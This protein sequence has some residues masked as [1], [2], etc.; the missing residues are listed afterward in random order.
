MFN[1]NKAFSRNIGWVSKEEQRLLKYKKIAVAGCGGVGSEHV[2]TLARLGIGRFSISDFDEYEVHNFNRQAGA[3]MSTIDRPKNTVMREV[4][5]DINPQ[6]H[7]D[8]FP[9]GVNEDNVDEFLRDVDVYVDGLDFFA[10]NARFM[11][12]KRCEE[13]GIPVIT[14]APM[15]MGASLVCF[16]PGSMPFEEYFDFASCKTEE[17]KLVKLTIG[18]SPTMMQRHYLTDPT[19]TDF[20]NKKVPSTPMGVKFC[21]GLAGSY[22]LKLLLNRGTVIKAPHSIHFDGF[23]NEVK[24]SWRPWGNK[25]PLQKFMF[26]QVKNIVLTEQPPLTFDD[27]MTTIE[28]VMDAAKWAPSG[29]NEQC[30]LF[31]FTSDMSCTVHGRDTRHSCVYDLQGNASKFAIGAL[32]ETAKISAT[33]VGCGIEIT[34]AEQSTDEH[35][36]YHIKLI[37]QDDV[38]FDELV[39]HIKTRAVQRK[40]MG[41]EPLTEIEKA[42]LLSVLPEGFEIVWFEPLELRR[43]VAKLIYGNAYTRVSM[44]EAHH[45]HRKIID[46]DKQF[47]KDKIPDQALGVNWLMRKVMKSALNKDWKQFEFMGKYLAGTVLPRFL[48][49]YRTSVRCSTHFALIAP[50]ECVS[51]ADYIKA[52]GVLQRFWLMADKLK[53]GFQPEYTQIVFS[54]YLRRDVTFTSN[55]ATIENA[56]QMEDKFI[57]LM[58]DQQTVA[59]VCY[60]GRL[61]RSERVASRSIRKD[62]S[63]LK[64][65]PPKDN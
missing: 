41:T 5:L 56:R 50:K 1:Y 34:Q 55:P 24:K 26:N 47:S 51:E 22:V 35:P 48:M 32:L 52:G 43:K 9:E 63:E 11:V 37:K 14:A 62:L 49:D 36:T 4:C 39:P 2:V 40:P 30:W 20:I 8:D 42:K 6:A 7:I 64:Y 29:D 10:M 57:D 21:G 28:K 13:L 33:E 16:M 65:V 44:E 27:D 58:G 3:F 25:N 18:L 54:E 19:T 59:K 61:G 46:W 31:E 17:E 23:L 15:A 45:H 53:L 60:F 12:F 38:I